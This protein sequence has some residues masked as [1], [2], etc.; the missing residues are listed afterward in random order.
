M[1]WGAAQAA[2]FSFPS[3]VQAGEWEN[4]QDLKAAL[5]R[6]PA[7]RDVPLPSWV[8]NLD[9]RRADIFYDVSALQKTE[10]KSNAST[11]PSPVPAAAPASDGSR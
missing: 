2:L 5:V 3:Q 6:S 10:K 9:Y 11:I 1:I 4:Y 7:R 8:S